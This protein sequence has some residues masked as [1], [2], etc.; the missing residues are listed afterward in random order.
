MKPEQAF[1][2]QIRPHLPGFPERIEN[3]AGAGTPDFHCIW[4]GVTYW[5]ECKAPK[6]KKWDLYKLLE[7]SQIAWYKRHDTHG[8]LVFFVV[9]DSIGIHLFNSI[10]NKIGVYS[11]ADKWAA[12]SCEINIQLLNKSN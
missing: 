10:T 5:V 7:P 8:G 9:K 11:G 2:Q 3:C 6:V 1:Y 4:Q 12:F